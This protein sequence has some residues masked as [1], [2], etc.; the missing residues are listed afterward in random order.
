MLT[1][2]RELIQLIAG[3]CLRNEGF[4]MGKLGFSEQCLLNFLPV[5]EKRPAEVSRRA[6]L[7]LLRFHCEKQIGI[8]PA[9]EEF[10][11]RYAAWYAPQVKQLDVIGLFHSP[12][13]KEILSAYN[14][15]SKVV[16]YVDTEPDRSRPD[17]PSLCYL[18]LFS[19]KK[20][21]LVAPFAHL[22]KERANKET[23]EKVWANTG[24]KWFYPSGLTSVEFP[25]SYVTEKETYREYGNSIN[26]FDN[27]CGQIDRQ[28]YDIAL[29]AAAGLGIPI[30]AHIKNKG[31]IGIS[32]GGHL[33]VL[34][35]VAGKRWKSD[36]SFRENYMNEHWM[37][38]P[39]SYKPLH[40]KILSDAGAYWQ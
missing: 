7:S 40:A 22:L 26:L 21:L 34:F 33:Q 16:H 30:A 27:I 36:S 17:D 1:N 4:A 38:M 18:P 15:N 31:K 35:G 2:K 32:L 13:E 19:N 9:T 10:L 37:D 3:A 20:I 8:F 11:H 24:K 14:I 29:I 28:E 5:M 39:D 23:F 12:Q 25:Y 6:Y